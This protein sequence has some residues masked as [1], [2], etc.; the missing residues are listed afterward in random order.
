MS[1][2]CVNLVSSKIP[3]RFCFTCVSDDCWNDG[4]GSGDC[5]DADQE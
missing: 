5:G 3:V 2:A 4:G 1:A